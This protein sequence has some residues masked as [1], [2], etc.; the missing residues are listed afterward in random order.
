MKWD[1]EWRWYHDQVQ[2]E[3]EIEKSSCLTDDPS[4]ESKLQS[5]I[6]LYILIFLI[7]ED[8][9]PPFTHQSDVLYP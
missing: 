7:L 8:M 6:G 3:M 5:W 2:E 4:S 1:L 9:N